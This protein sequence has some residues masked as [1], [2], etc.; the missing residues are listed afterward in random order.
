LAEE[1][2][3]SVYSELARQ[4]PGLSKDVV[5]ASWLRERTRKMAVRILRAD[6][7]AIDWAALRRE[8]SALSTPADAHLAPPGLAIRICQSIYLSTARHK[9]HGLFSTRV[10]WPAW[11]RPA[12]VGGVAVCVLVMIVW[13]RVPFHRRNAIVQS[14][15]SLMTPSSYAQLAS[16]EEARPSMPSHM[17]NTNAGTATNQK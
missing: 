13:W 5:L 1:I 17:V 2:A 14:Q 4:A 16:S 3:L 12:H 15:G 10:W 11:I 6:G 8:K 7:R 9:G